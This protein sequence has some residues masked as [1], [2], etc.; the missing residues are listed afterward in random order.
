MKLLIDDILQ[1]ITLGEAAFDKI[2]QQ[3]CSGRNQTQDNLNE[4]ILC[5]FFK[6]LELRLC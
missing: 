2:Y 6:M 3:C 5:G 1:E 4:S